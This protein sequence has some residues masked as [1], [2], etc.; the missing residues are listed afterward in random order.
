MESGESFTQSI[1]QLPGK[2]MTDAYQNARTLAQEFGIKVFPSGP[3]WTHAAR[4]LATSDLAT[5]EAIHAVDPECGW[6]ARCSAE[7]GLIVL[8]TP[9]YSDFQELTA[10]LGA[11]PVT[12]M[13]GRPSGS[14]HRWF[15]ADARD[16]DLRWGHCLFAT[17]AFFKQSVAVPGTRHARGEVYDWCG[18]Q[19]KQCSLQRLPDEWLWGVPHA[20][21]SAGGIEITPHWEWRPPA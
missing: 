7:D 21:G 5:L 4:D 6:R 18:F 11:L 16:P 1:R 2:S 12:W 10:E 14:I 20:T 19:P 8:D 15:A 9:R 17:R 13:S 3:V